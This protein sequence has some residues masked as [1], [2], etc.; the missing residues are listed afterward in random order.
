MEVVNFTKFLASVGLNPNDFDDE[1]ATL[2]LVRNLVNETSPRIL[3]EGFPRTEK[4][5]RLFIRNCVSPSEVF[6]IKCSKDICQERVLDLGQAN[7]GYVSSSV[8]TQQIKNFNDHAVTLIPFLKSL[9]TSFREVNGEQIL[10]NVLK[11]VCAVVEPT[12]IHVRH[13]VEGTQELTKQIIEELTSD[14]WGYANI[15]I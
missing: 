13:G 14:K 3:I 6:Y 15:E 7:P 9:T 1:E 11:E 8:L 12:V 5:A 10:A 2:A 4:Q